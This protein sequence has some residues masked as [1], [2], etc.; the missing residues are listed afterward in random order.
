MELL[1]YIETSQFGH[2]DPPLVYG[3]TY[4]SPL[5]ANKPALNADPIW[6]YSSIEKK[7]IKTNS[8]KNMI[9]NFD[10]ESFVL[11]P[12]MYNRQEINVQG[13]KDWV[14][15]N[16]KIVEITNLNRTKERFEV[17]NFGDNFRYF[18]K[19]QFGWLN[20]RYLMWN[21]VGRQNELLGKGDALAGNWE[22]GI[23]FIDKG[24]IGDKKERPDYFIDNPT[25]R[26]YYGLPFILGIIGIVFLFKKHSALAWVSLIFFLAFSLAITIFINQLPNNVYIRE[27]DYVFLS[28]YFIFS[29][30]IGLGVLALYHWIKINTIELNKLKIIV[31]ACFL[32]VPCLMA[33]EG[34]MPSDRSDNNFAYKLA[35]NMLAQCEHEGLVIANGDNVTFPL[36]YLQEVEGFRKD[37][38][39]ID[40]NLLNLD[41]Y[42]DKLLVK[43]N[44]A[45]PLNL[46]LSREFYT[47][48]N[49]SL[50]NL[51][52]KLEEPLSVN[53]LSQKLQK[54]TSGKK[55]I[56]SDL[57]LFDVA[58]ENID[59]SYI[60]SLNGK[61]LP[62]LVWRLNKPTYD[63]KDIVL[64]DLLQQNNFKKAVYFTN[65]GRAP[66]Y[67]GLEQHFVNQG[68]LYEF[69]PIAPLSEKGVSKMVDIQKIKKWCFNDENFDVK[70]DSEKSIASENL[71]FMKASYKPIFYELA[72]AYK[73]EQK[74]DSSILVLKRLEKLFPNESVP[75]GNTL[76]DAAIIYYEL[77]LIDDWRRVIRIV[78]D[79]NINKMNWLTS[80]NPNHKTI[81]FKS[82]MNIGNNFNKIM[83]IVVQRDADLAKELDIKLKQLDMQYK[84]WVSDNQSYFS[85]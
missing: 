19:F 85:E 83:P 69:L 82:I 32:L 45:P 49:T 7:Y 17:P 44:D 55:T 13:Y 52:L 48:G 2:L 36:W 53:S 54:S 56:N 71:D 51:D 66:F 6:V 24:R 9:P 67:L 40:Y 72:L 34:W 26:I 75:Y 27:R 73:I 11:F 33:K 29:M 22:S 39:V 62:Q 41:W 47:Y 77:G 63:L 1:Y 70:P 65:T 78:M 25:K 43:Q 79:N 28:A 23:N 59:T 50:F 37:V 61:P 5:N 46:S 58:L 74:N 64:M 18:F 76:V 20:W 15:S 80:F 42:I 30:W 81:T 60:K 8:G 68:L 21:F 14:K 31:V 35:K 57:F 84:G 3:P 10:K 4:A 16:N 38:R 12:R